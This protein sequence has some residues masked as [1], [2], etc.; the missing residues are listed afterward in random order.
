MFYATCF[1]FVKKVAKLNI[2]KNTVNFTGLVNFKK[3]YRLA[4]IG[5][6]I[7]GLEINILLHKAKSLK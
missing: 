2:L 6:L 7:G 4:R 5:F 1:C 3:F